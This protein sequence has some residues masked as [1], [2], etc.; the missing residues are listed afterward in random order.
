MSSLSV[1]SLNLSDRL[2]SAKPRCAGSEHASLL[3][4]CSTAEDAEAP[5]SY[6]T[7]PGSGGSSQA[8]WDSHSNSGHCTWLGLSCPGARSSS[9]SSQEARLLLQDEVLSWGLLFFL[10]GQCQNSHRKSCG[11]AFGGFALEG[12][13]PRVWR[14]VAAF[15]LHL[16]PSW[17]GLGG[18]RVGNRIVHCG[19]PLT[20][21]GTE[22]YQLFS[23][24]YR[25]RGGG[26][27][28][29][30]HPIECL[31]PARLRLGCLPVDCFMD[32]SC[33]C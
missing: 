32:S 2:L 9:S 29:E 27:R 13:G 21:L 15:S 1:P 25:D 16:S 4:T 11:R 19:P 14:W 23:L 12:S 5:R 3:L 28:K 17:G 8:S 30:T 18:P 26:G 22:G 10:R 7:L 20:T 6:V 33:Q 24:N 31:L